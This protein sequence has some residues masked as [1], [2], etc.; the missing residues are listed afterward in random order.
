MFSSAKVITDFITEHFFLRTYKKW[1]WKL[2][3]LRK[4][5][6]MVERTCKQ[7]R[8]DLIIFLIKIQ[9]VING[10]VLNVLT[11]K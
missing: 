4:I 9:Y 3:Y 6:C 11:I 10:N 5:L 2:V 7:F 1:G 8:E